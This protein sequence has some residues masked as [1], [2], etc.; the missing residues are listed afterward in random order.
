MANFASHNEPSGAEK[1]TPSVISKADA[2][3]VVP[4]SKILSLPSFAYPM[5]LKGLKDHLHEGQTICVTPG[6]GSFDWFAR[7][8][9]GEDLV[10][11]ITILWV[12]CQMPFHC[13]IEEFGKIANVQELKKKYCIGVSHPMRHF[14]NVS[15]SRRICS[16]MHNLLESDRLS[17]VPCTP[18]QSHYLAS[19]R[20][21]LV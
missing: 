2:T 3:D 13:R 8:I 11:E 20:V 7:N 6:Q 1:G 12:S 19:T 14:R 21:N 16:D 15:S 5:I 9:L 10:S 17:S 18:S 4:G